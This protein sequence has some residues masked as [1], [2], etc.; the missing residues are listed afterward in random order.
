MVVRS[1]F[2]P[3]KLAGPKWLRTT[4]CKSCNSTLGQAVDNFADHPFFLALRL[5]A[6]L[7][8][9][10]D[11]DVTY[12]HP[13]TGELRP[14]RI[15][16]DGSIVEP[17]YVHEGEGRFTVYAPTV[18]GAQAIGERRAQ[19]RAAR[20]ETTKLLEPELIELGPQIMRTTPGVVPFEDL[21]ERILREA[22]KI[23]VGYLARVGSPQLALDTR[24]DPVRDLALHGTPL[25][26]AGVGALLPG[27]PVR[28]Y[29]PSTHQVLT[30][31]T[32]GAELPSDEQALAQFYDGEGRP[33]H[34]PEGTVRLTRMYHL[35]HV[36][37]SA[38][39]AWVRVTFFGVVSAHVPIPSDIPA[40]W[41]RGDTL[42]F[43]SSGM[44]QRMGFYP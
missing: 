27:E 33:R 21:S 14:A 44:V 20:G 43:R 9:G 30:F 7:P 40:P 19:R 2:V 8:V 37:R 17:P 28:L 6:G 16:S 36:R 31:G 15:R 4:I 18:E 42:E 34:E 41:G 23:A 10:R 25:E 32:A 38:G 22:A 12:E 1:Q 5:E 24:L 26:G 13:G 35:V 39:E 3:Q 29:L 11:L